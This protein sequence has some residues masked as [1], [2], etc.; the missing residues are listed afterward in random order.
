MMLREATLKG[1]MCPL[2]NVPP[3]NYLSWY[4]AC[5]VWR[6]QKRCPGT[7]PASSRC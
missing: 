2:T 4:L 1:R 5:S 3:M 6:L 7:K